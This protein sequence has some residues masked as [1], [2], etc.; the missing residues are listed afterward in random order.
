MTKDST[1]RLVAVSGRKRD[2]PATLLATV[3]KGS[4]R[5]VIFSVPKSW[6]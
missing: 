5:L 6:K 3:N 4:V 2:F 1:R